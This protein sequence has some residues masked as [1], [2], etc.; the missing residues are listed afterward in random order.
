MDCTYGL[1]S[2]AVTAAE[3]SSGLLDKQPSL[4]LPEISIVALT[5]VNYACLP[6]LCENI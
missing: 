6:P 2:K 4:Q 5:P 1:H 3:K